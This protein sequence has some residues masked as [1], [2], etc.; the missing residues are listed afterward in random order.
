[1]CRYT[2]FW[3]LAC[4]WPVLV[5]GR[6]WRDAVALGFGFLELLASASLVGLVRSLLLGG[7]W[8]LRLPGP[9]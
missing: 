9:L 8:P 5:W 6:T 7:Q 3:V 4:A 1:M 2:L